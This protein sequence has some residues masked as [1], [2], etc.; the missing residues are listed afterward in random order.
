[1]REESNFGPCH[2]K[3]PVA[4]FEF[5]REELEAMYH[6]IPSADAASRDVQAALDWME[7]LGDDQKPS[8]EE[9]K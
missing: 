8:Q 9:K 7:T 4:I 5:D 2:P 6:W 1:M 3:G